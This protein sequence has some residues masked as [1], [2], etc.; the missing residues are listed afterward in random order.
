MSPAPI[1]EFSNSFG[2]YGASLLMSW[3][4]VAVNVSSLL[5]VVSVGRVERLNVRISGFL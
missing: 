4:T 5:S 1:P 2:N 3:F